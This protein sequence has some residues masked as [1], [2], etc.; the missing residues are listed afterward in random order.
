MAEAD[1]EQEALRLKSL[2]E[3]DFKSS[4]PKSALKH[5]KAAYRLFPTLPGLSEMVI[6]FKILAAASASINSGMPDYYGILQ[7]EPFSHINSIRKQYKSLA[8]SIH[9]DK[10][11]SLGSEEAFKVVGDAFRVLNDRI[12]RKEYDMKLRIRMQE[13][14]SGGNSLMDEVVM[15]RFWTACSWCKILHQ[16]EKKYLGH[17]LVCPSCGKSFRAVEIGDN[18]KDVDG[19]WDREEKLSEREAGNAK[20]KQKAISVDESEPKRKASSVD[21]TKWGIADSGGGRSKKRESEMGRVGNMTEKR[22]NKNATIVE[23]EMMTLA[24]M[25]LEAMQKKNRRKI[26]L[27]EK[28]KEK[29]LE[30]E[31]TAEKTS[32][33]IARD[34]ETW[35]VSDN[36]EVMRCSSSMK[37]EHL[38]VYRRGTWRR[39]NSTDKGIERAEK[40][41]NQNMEIMLVEDS[42]FYDFDKDRSERRF[43]KGQVWSVYDKVDGMPRSYCLINEVSLSPF[44]LRVS[45]LDLQGSV[46]H[47]SAKAASTLPCGQFKVAQRTALKSV[48][49]LSHVVDCERAAREL[50]R[51]FPKKG[52]IWALHGNKCS[53]DIVVFL[54]SYSE[55]FGLSMAYLVRVD[56]FKTVFKRQEIGAHAVHLLNKTDLGVCSHQIPARKLEGSEVPSFLKECWEL[57]PAALPPDLLTIPTRRE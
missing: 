51:I 16:F 32:G 38:Q 18:N 53:Y 13:E 34:T 39:N 23:E 28:E 46:R 49:L 12:R 9:P 2:A 27:R 44:T 15:E 17:N 19:N 37:T 14:A 10:N 6:C 36:S 1:P 41:K 43:K 25:Q 24:E 21:N 33:K 42:D 5:A 35:Q 11:V 22:V 7:V 56:G 40:S 57:D 8:L 50:Y 3:A 4:N 31:G 29:G 55:A 48:K 20:R 30:K 47:P 52:S 54:T 26:M 45:C